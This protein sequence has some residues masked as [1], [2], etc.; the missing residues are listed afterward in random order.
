MRGTVACRRWAQ[1]CV[2]ASSHFGLQGPVPVSRGW[3]STLGVGRVG[4]TDVVTACSPSGWGSKGRAGHRTDDPYSSLIGNELM[5]A[6]AVVWLEQ[7]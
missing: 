5:V 3:M 6:C 7:R 4:R 2:S 1:L